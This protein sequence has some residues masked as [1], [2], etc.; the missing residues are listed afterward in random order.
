LIFVFVR[1]GGEKTN[2][3]HIVSDILLVVVIS[4]IFLIPISNATP[5][6]DVLL[7]AAIFG[8]TYGVGASEIA[9][10]TSI[11][12]NISTTFGNI[13]YDEHTNYYGSGTTVNKVK[14][15][16]GDTDMEYW[17]L[18]H[19]GEGSY[20]NFWIIVPPFHT[21]HWYY[22][23]N[24]GE[25]IK[26]LEIFPQT[27]ARLWYFVFLWSCHQGDVIGG[28][29]PYTGAY[30]MPYAWHHTNALSNDGYT[31]PDSGSQCFIGFNRDARQFTDPGM[32]GECQ[33]FLLRFYH[34]ALKGHETIKQSL[35]DAAHYAWGV[36]DFAHC[37]LH[38]GYYNEQGELCNMVV[39]GNGNKILPHKW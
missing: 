39:Y 10:C 1:N 17:T 7:G 26:D 28:W 6:P 38:T 20:W 32:G 24:S 12:N 31:T 9:A 18:F 37:I 2:N 13:G 19:V 3:Y 30:G 4:L 25:W 15:V 36:Q 5:P 35:N 21:V 34:V 33:D 22:V 27:G 29:C 16:A 23:D 11:T 14:E 8:S